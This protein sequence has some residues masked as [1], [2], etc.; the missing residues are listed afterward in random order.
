MSKLRIYGDTSGYID[1]AAPATADNSTLDL[2]TVAKTNSA[3][4]FTDT[5]EVYKAGTA[6]VLIGSDNGGTAQLSFY[7]ANT[8]TKEAF[9]KYDGLANTFNLGTSGSGNAIAIGRD[10]GIVTMPYQP[11]FGARG[12]N[13][14]ASATNVATYTLGTGGAYNVGSHY[15]FTNSRFTAPVAGRYLFTWNWYTNNGS[16]GETRITIN[17]NYADGTYGPLSRSNFSGTNYTNIHA[18]A[19]LSLAATDYA[20]IYITGGSAYFDNDCWF[21]GILIG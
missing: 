17:G 8:S 10:T 7:E 13:G 12:A 19:V 14:G 5:L 1:V 2:S 16:L 11:A 15:N 18:S 6:E 4:T 21:T 20:E 9:I 3:N